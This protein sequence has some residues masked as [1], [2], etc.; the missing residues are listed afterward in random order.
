MNKIKLW[1]DDERVEPVGWLRASDAPNAIQAIQ[2]YLEYLE[3]ISF[4]YDIGAYGNGALVAKSLK[5][6]KLF[7]DIKFNI[8]SENPKGIIELE[9]ILAEIL[10]EL[11]HPK[12]NITYYSNSQINMHPL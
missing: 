8:H 1:I 3:A 11:G 7:T 9:A 4:D 10:E 2:L 12:T 6:L 5:T